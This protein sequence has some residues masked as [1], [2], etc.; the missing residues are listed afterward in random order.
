VRCP[1]TSFC[2]PT[3]TPHCPNLTP[4]PVWCSRFCPVTEPPNCQHTEALECTRLGAQCPPASGFNCPSGFCVGG[5][6]LGGD[7]FAAR[8]GVQP[9]MVDRKQT[10]YYCTWYCPSFFGPNCWA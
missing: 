7:P 1:H 4:S 9:G 2:A 10:Y 5:G 3:D 8:G 6:G